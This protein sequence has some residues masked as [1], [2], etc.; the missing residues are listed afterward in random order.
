MGTTLSIQDVKLLSDTSLN[1]TKRGIS[2]LF[3]HERIIIPLT[4]CEIVTFNVSIA[5]NSSNPKQPLFSAGI[6]KNDDLYERK[7]LSYYD[8][9]KMPPTF[10]NIDILIAE[11]HKLRTLFKFIEPITTD[12]QE[13]VV[14]LNNLKL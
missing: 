7:D 5:L 1:L 6:V 9:T 10:A 4:N 3:E 2:N 11:I 14:D 13:M 8:K 12:E